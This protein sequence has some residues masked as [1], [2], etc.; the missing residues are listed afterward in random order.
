MRFESLQYFLEV[1]QVGS[2]SSAARRLYISHQGLGKSIRLLEQELGVTLF[3]RSGKRV[4]LT[5]AGVDLVPLARRCLDDQKILMEAMNRHVSVTYESKLRLIAVPFVAISLFNHM[6]SRLSAYD[7]RDVV[8]VEKGLPEIVRE[9]TDPRQSKETLAMVAVPDCMLE[10]LREQGDV[11]FVPLFSSQL[12]ILSTKALLSPR[13]RSVSI[14]EASGLPVACY[15]EPILESLL[16]NTFAAC[17][18]RDVVT[19]TTNL[20]LISEYVESG[21]AVTFGDS[22][23]AYL[24]E[25][26]SG[27]FFVPIKGAESFL[28]GFLHSTDSDCEGSVFSYMARFRACVEQT[29]GAYS[30]KHPLPTALVTTSSE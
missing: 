20:Q 4:R 23:S 22:L 15:S 5:E 24:D 28:I 25:A 12:G 3:E 13:K 8:L 19:S 1:A 7:L 17:P 30:E 29:C 16:E 2:F 9:V 26:S 10:A 11:E 6:K 21:E 14:E 27:R 18:L